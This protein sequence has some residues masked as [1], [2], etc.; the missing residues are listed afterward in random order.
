MLFPTIY[1][2]THVSENM[3]NKT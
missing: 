1:M 2:Q 3:V